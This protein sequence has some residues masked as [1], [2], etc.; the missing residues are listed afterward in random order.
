MIKH[1][2]SKEI[3]LNGQWY[4]AYD[5]E[6]I[7]KAERWEREISGSARPAIFPGFVQDTIAEFQG[8][9]A[10]YWNEFDLD[11]LPADQDSFLRLC[12]YEYI[13]ELWVNGTYLGRAE[14]RLL[15]DEFECTKALREGKNL[16][17]IRLAVPG[18]EELEGYTWNDLPVLFGPDRTPFGGIWDPVRLSFRPRLRTVAPRLIADYATGDVT[19]DYSVKNNTGRKQTADISYAIV[20]D[21]KENVVSCC[22]R[23]VCPEGDTDVHAVFHVDHFIPWDIDNPFLYTVTVSVSGETQKYTL[24]LDFGFR[25]FRVKD[26]WFHLNG[27]RILIKGGF[28]TEGFHY[29]GAP[30]NSA[31]LRKELLSIKTMGVNFLR[32]HNGVAKEE[33]L[34]LCDRIGILVVEAHAAS[35]GMRE[36]GKALEEIYDHHL[37]HTMEQGIN[38]TSIVAWELIN[39]SNNKR[40]RD[41]AVA[42]LQTLRDHDMTRV[43]F[44]GSGRW[45]N[46]LRIGS[47]SN[48]GSRQWECVW[49]QESP[50]APPAE[51]P[52]STLFSDPDLGTWTFREDDTVCW[53]P[54]YGDVHIY[55]RMPMTWRGKYIFKNHGNHGSKPIYISELGTS[56]LGNEIKMT[57]HFERLP[58][59]PKNS[60]IASCVYCAEF[61]E[62]E[63]AHYKLGDEYP[64]PEDL[65]L[66]SQKEDAYQWAS[67]LDNVRANP[68]CAGFTFTCGGG[69]F[70]TMQCLDLF[71]DHV[72]FKT[73]AVTECIKP[74]HWC[75]LVDK[76][77]V[78]VDQTFTV[79]AVL[80]VDDG[81]MQPGTYPVT[82]RIAAPGSGC[83]WE[84]KTSATIPETPA[85]GYAPICYP[86]FKEKVRIPR[87]GRYSCVVNLD[88]GGDP[89]GGRQEI[90]VDADDVFVDTTAQLVGL[91]SEQKEW[92]SRHGV[93]E[94]ADADLIVLGCAKMSDDAFA[95][96]LERV[97]AG[98]TLI[99]L[100]PEVLFRTDADP[101]Q[102]QIPLVPERLPAKNKGTLLFTDNWAYRV[103]TV[104]KKS[105][106]S[107]GLPAGLLEDRYW[108]QVEPMFVFQNMD[109][110]DFIA[111]ATLG[112]PYFDKSADETNGTLTGVTLGE[113]KC[114][115]GR[116]VVNCYRI[117][118]ELGNNPAAGRLLLNMLK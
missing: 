21:N 111:S 70:S 90:I 117:L 15:I 83:V 66:A 110:P 3:E 95:P 9:V 24:Q 23:I 61:L 76:E 77:H 31:L 81:Q 27:K 57:R 114:G 19:L 54:R 2:S 55:T 97:R 118:D 7:G 73:E 26:G 10:W 109:D 100:K 75:L 89:S 6:Q 59:Q 36:S 48:P 87:A 25:D 116:M 88:R 60:R 20:S 78:Y 30:S 74:L 4:V 16:L 63:F 8:G 45:D 84:Y 91:D 80:A 32:Y 44:L 67:I 104:L 108:D 37:L 64:F 85:N 34:D 17:A 62:K 11:H 47:I 65:V 115:S 99:V 79:E 112:A 12:F 68:K 35:W 22:D 71:K 33:I 93:R 5:K 28:V 41:H 52:M 42:V 51:S 72:P 56:P 102:W 13:V 113:Y 18:E 106:Y 69:N 105:K 98:A 86:V 96:L 82:A 40:E 29:W 50:D 38:H 1:F 103:H 43:V 92:L 53:D 58:Y 94:N 46:E 14:G 107:E 39:E 49:G 101:Y